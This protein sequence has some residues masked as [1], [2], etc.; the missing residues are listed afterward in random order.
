MIRVTDVTEEERIELERRAHS[1]T[2]PH[3][4]VQRARMVLANRDGESA[5]TIAK[6]LGMSHVTVRKWLV[7]FQACRLAGLDEFPRSGRKRPE[8]VSHRSEMVR[9]VR[10][11]P[12]ELGKPFATWTIERLQ[13]ALLDA[14]GRRFSTRTLWAWLRAEGLRWQKQESWLRPVLHTPEAL[15]DFEEKRG[16][17]SGRISTPR[18]TP[19]SRER[20]AS[21]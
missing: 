16:F 18:R 4:V 17:S 5:P 3:R 9:L 21:A 20:N 7:R 19:N 10:T 13:E 1:Q 6:R 8:N 2:M 15:A 11:P 12:S 14:V